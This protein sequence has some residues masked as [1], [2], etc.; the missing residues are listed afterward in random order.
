MTTTWC[1]YNRSL[2]DYDRSRSWWIA[3]QRYVSIAFVLAFILESGFFDT[4]VCLGLV[5]NFIH[6][7]WPSLLRVDNFLQEFTPPIV[8]CT[9]GKPVENFYTM[10]EYNS[11]KEDRDLKKWHVKYYKGLGTST[12]AEAKVYFS[13]LGTHRIQFAYEDPA[14]F[15]AID[16][17]FS[18]KRIV[19]R[20]AW[21]QG[22]S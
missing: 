3:Y 7:F 1:A 15:D 8:K 17:A 12:A 20:K 5:I 10:P 13:D 4:H 19:D 2:D 21:L 18:K 6:H 9:K 11:W 22:N 16:M 14:D